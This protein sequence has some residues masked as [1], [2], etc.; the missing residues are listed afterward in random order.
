MVYS[1]GSQSNCDL[2]VHS[3]PAPPSTTA[4]VHIMIRSALR[5]GTIITID[6]IMT[7]TIVRSLGREY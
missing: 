2:T 6:G 4:S 3:S 7:G 1:P 5:E